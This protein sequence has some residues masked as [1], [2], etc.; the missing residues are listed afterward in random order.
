MGIVYAAAVAFAMV[1]LDEL[2][3]A[4]KTTSD[5]TAQAPDISNYQRGAWADSNVATGSHGRP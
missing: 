2:P 4:F 1:V 5:P 3:K